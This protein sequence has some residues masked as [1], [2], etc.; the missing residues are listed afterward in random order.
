[1]TTPTPAENE[2]LDLKPKIE[3]AG[4]EYQLIVSKFTNKMLRDLDEGHITFILDKLIGR[5]AADKFIDTYDDPA[6]LGE[7]MKATLEVIGTK[8]S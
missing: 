2:A 7:F 6:T 1:M 8:N 5:E 4:K 3:F